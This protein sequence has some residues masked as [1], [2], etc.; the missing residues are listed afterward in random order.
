MSLQFGKALAVHLSKRGETQR[1]FAGAVKYDQP[2]LAQI[3]SG[4]RKP[5][6]DHLEPWAD[7]LGLKGKDRETF[8]ILGHLEHCTPYIQDFVRRIRFSDA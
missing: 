6:V 4:S 7:Y 8:L 5:P 3:I 2:S 1:Q